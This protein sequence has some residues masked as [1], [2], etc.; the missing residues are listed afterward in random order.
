MT[1]ASEK[2]RRFRL[3]RTHM[4]LLALSHAMQRKGINNIEVALY[5][6]LCEFGDSGPVPETSL[7]REILGIIR[8]R[9]W[10]AL[11]AWRARAS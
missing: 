2:P 11:R 6:W 8:S 9:Y 4:N 7:A 1:S 5:L 10:R 3:K